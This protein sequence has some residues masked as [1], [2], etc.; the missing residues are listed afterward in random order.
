MRTSW[1]STI[2]Q[3]FPLGCQNSL[4]RL[5]TGGGFATRQL[6][7]D[8][9]EVLI[10]VRRPTILNGIEEFVTR[11]D[12]ADRAVFLNLRPIDEMDR[13]SEN[14]L[15]A[16]FDVNRPAILG[17]LLDAMAHGLRT[18]PSVILERAPRMADFA[19]WS[20]ACET[21]FWPTGTFSAAYDNNRKNAVD[22]V[23]EADPV[24]SAIRVLMMGQ[25]AWQG[26]A[27]ALLAVLVRLVDEPTR[28]SRAWPTSPAKLSGNLRR[29]VTFLRTIGIEIEMVREGHDRQR[30]IRIA[31]AADPAVDGAEPD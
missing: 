1:R 13:K 23:I 28:R 14:E 31:R 9:D 10:D 17:A 16:E 8:R 24:A 11:P 22:S 4:C 3:R 27:T 20:T 15:W 29:A 21:A 2:F 18:L 26:T 12:L 6:Y 19:K 7:T 5:A 25:D 30:V